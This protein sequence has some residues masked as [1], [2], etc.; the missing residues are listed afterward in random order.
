LISTLYYFLEKLWCAAAGTGEWAVRFPSAVYGVAA[1]LGTFLLARALF[2]P[3]VGLYAA[4]FM[5]VN[6]FAVYYSQE[7]RPYALFLAAAVFSV[8]YV[9][10]VLR[11]GTRG[12]RVGYLVSTAVDTCAR[13]VRVRSY[14]L[15][16]NETVNE[17]DLRIA[18]GRRM[19][20]EQLIAESEKRNPYLY[21]ITPIR[22][23][24]YAR[25]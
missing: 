25:E 13:I 6:P 3:V 12:S 22:V 20:S 2:S 23:T 5:A 7:A 17:L 14:E 9:L 19:V 15:E 24:L 16:P 10:E 11:N 1:V 21:W 18:A 8:Y 4:L